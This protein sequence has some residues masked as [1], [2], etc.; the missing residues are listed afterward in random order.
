MELRFSAA[1]E[2]AAARERVIELTHTTDLETVQRFDPRVIA[3]AT[4]G[5]PEGQAGRWPG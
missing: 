3:V 4:N 2:V 1:T 5:V